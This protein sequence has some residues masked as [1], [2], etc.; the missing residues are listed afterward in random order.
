[1]KRS[2]SC[3]DQDSHQ[4][5][6]GDPQSDDRPSSGLQPLALH[7]EMACEWLQQVSGR[8]TKVKKGGPGY[9]ESHTIRQLRRL[10]KAEEDPKEA[11]TQW[12]AIWK[13]RKMEKKNFARDLADKAIRQDRWAFKKIRSAPRRQWQAHLLS[14]DGWEEQ[15][16]THFQVVFA[17]DDAEVRSSYLDQ[18]SEAASC[19]CANVRR[20]TSLIRGNSTSPPKPGN[21][22][23]A[24]PDGLSYEAV[25]GIYAEG[26][27]WALG[28]QIQMADMYSDALYKG[29]LPSAS[30]SVTT[31]LA[32]KPS[33]CSWGDTRRIT[34]SCTALKILAQLLLSGGRHQLTDPHGVQ[35]SEQGKQT[36]EVIFALRRLSRMALDWGKPIF[37]LKLDIRNAQCGPSP[38]GGIHFQSNCS[39]RGNAVGRDSGYSLYGARNCSYKQMGGHYDPTVQRS[40]AR[41]PR[42]SGAW[43]YGGSHR[44]H[45]SVHRGHP[46][47]HPLQWKHL[48]G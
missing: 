34:L 31:L 11:A 19:M 26:E 39:Y 14:Q 47:A 16:R 18:G 30:D 32:K 38:F 29:Y 7:T 28:G 36:G 27:L 40:P 2:R 48:H 12:K 43:P 35:W 1:M 3:G 24:G 44:A 13:L 15:A 9:Q 17:R 41:V 33:P 25:K 4:A 10:A 8:I 6:G 42:L 21:R 20:C 5:Q 46:T 22:G 45:F 23:K 37:V